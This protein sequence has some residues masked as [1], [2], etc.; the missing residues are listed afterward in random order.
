M[1]NTTR[2]CTCFLAFAKTLNFLRAAEGLF[3]TPQAFTPIGEK[4]VERL[5]V[6]DEVYDSQISE[7]YRKIASDRESPALAFSLL[8][9][10][11][12]S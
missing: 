11:S 1:R 4:C 2:I 6:I 5:S 3:M 12:S 8:F 7:V 9:S 10:K